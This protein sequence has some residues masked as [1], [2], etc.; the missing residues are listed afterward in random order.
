MENL[1][2]R[3]LRN[4]AEESAAAYR[5]EQGILRYLQIVLLNV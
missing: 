5:E 3:L 1:D 4:Q 2:S